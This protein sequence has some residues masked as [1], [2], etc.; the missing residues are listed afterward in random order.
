[1]VK[2]LYRGFG[3]VLIGESGGPSPRSSTPSRRAALGAIGLRSYWL[4]WIAPP[5]VASVAAEGQG[6]ESEPF[7]C[8]WRS[9]GGRRARRPRSLLRPPTPAST[10]IPSGTAR[11][12][13]PRTRP[14][15]P[16]PVGRASPRHLPSRRGSRTSP[17]PRSDVAS[18]V[19]S[20]LHIAAG[21]D[22]G[23]RRYVGHCRRRPNDR[24]AWLD[25]Q[26]VA[27]LVITLW[28]SG[29]FFTRAGRRVLVGGKSQR[30]SLLRR[31]R[32]PSLVCRVGSP[33][34][35]KRPGGSPTWPNPSP[36]RPV[37]IR[38][39]GARDRYRDGAERAY[40]LRR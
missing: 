18:V 7:T 39:S 37:C 33:T 25:R 27:V 17:F 35:P 9:R 2:Y 22:G 15:S 30:S 3:V 24:L 14:S 13:I 31:F 19:R 29:L 11:R 5:I 32:T 8:W 26:G 20:R 40:V 6:L 23:A 10:C 4:W 16:A 38:L 28:A 1:M 36:G 21:A 12:S 34:P